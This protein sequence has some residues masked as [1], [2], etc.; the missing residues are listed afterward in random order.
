MHPAFV[1]YWQAR[2][3][4]LEPPVMTPASRNVRVIEPVPPQESPEPPRQGDTPARPAAKQVAIFQAIAPIHAVMQDF[5]HYPKLMPLD[6][7]RH[8][9][10]GDQQPWEERAN[11]ARIPA[12]AYGSLVTM[13]PANQYALT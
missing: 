4:P 6:N 5:F 9:L 3:E 1:G 10:T 2:R 12:V 11:L 8:V 13:D 7:N